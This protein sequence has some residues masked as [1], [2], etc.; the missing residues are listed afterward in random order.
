MTNWQEKWQNSDTPW[1]LNAPHPLLVKAQQ[2]LSKTGLW[3]NSGRA[4]VPA[5]GRCHDGA[6]LAELGW[7]VLGGDIVAEAIAS[8]QSIYSD[9]P[10]LKLKQIDHF[11]LAKANLGFFELVFDRAASCAFAA[12]QQRE[13]IVKSFEALKPDGLYIS[14][15]FQQ[16]AEGVPGPPF[17]LLPESFEQIAELGTFVLLEDHPKATPLDKIIT[18]RIIV[19]KKR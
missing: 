10:N 17:A 11:S 15:A 5:C 4:Y 6:F 3:P 2:H 8:A 16:I 19:A 18:E 1:D 12:E 14:V 13:F 9:C 7:S